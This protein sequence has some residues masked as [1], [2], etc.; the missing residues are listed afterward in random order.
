MTQIDPAKER[1]RLAERYAGMSDGELEKLSRDAG[2]LTDE[3]WELLEDELDRRGLQAATADALI[4]EDTLEQRKLTTLAQFR[5]LP[6]ALLAK[7]LLESAGIEC[8]LADDNMVR[9]DWFISNLLGGI[10][11][12]VKPED[13]AAA[14]EILEQPIPENFDLQGDGEF[15]QPRCPKCGSV[16][17]SYEAMNKGVGLTLGW[18]VGVPLP[19]R[20]DKWQCRVC[21]TE[22]REE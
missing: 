6:A 7:G 14:L 3:S 13:E 19:I 20:S 17:I 16:D 9:L 21:G 22:W 2:T 8:F 1:A 5:D 18:A 11:L 10:K 15:E 12:Q 4:V